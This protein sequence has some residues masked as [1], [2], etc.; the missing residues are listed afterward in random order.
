MHVSAFPR[1]AAW[2]PSPLPVC[3]G[4]GACS[5]GFYAEIAE[6]A[7]LNIAASASDS[8]MRPPRISVLAAWTIARSTARCQETGSHV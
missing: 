6:I 1:L 3:S 2:L 8:G 4:D 5:R 7:V